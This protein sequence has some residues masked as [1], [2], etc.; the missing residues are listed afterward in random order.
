[1]ALARPRIALTKKSTNHESR[2][3]ETG[4]HASVGFSSFDRYTRA[5]G[6]RPPQDD[7]EEPDSLAFGIAALDERLDRAEVTYPTDAEE[8]VRE[9]GDPD[10][11]YDPSGHSMALSEALEQIGKNRFDA[12]DELLDALHPVFEQRRRSGPSGLLDRLRSLF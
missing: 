11:A 8:V 6:V 7:A 2:L 4:P 9:L 3:A 5:M 10:I 1:M 12:E